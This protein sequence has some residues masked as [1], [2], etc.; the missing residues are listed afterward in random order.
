MQKSDKAMVVVDE[1]NLASSSTSGFIRVLHVD[2]DLSFLE[3]SRQILSIEG[4]F[5]IDIETSVD[6]AF[7]R[8]RSQSY[9]VVIC[10]YE[11]PK[12]DG[13]QFLKELREEKSEIPF[14]LFTGKGREEVAIKALN[15]G[16]DAY[17][18]KLGD[19]ETVYG[20]LSHALLKTVERKRSKK[21]LADSELKYRSLVEDMLQGIIIA[22]G[23]QP[24]IVFANPAMERITGFS[25]E[26]LYS[27]SP[28][29][30]G[31]LIHPSDREVFLN[32]LS[33]RYAGEDIESSYEFRGIRKDGSMT[34]VEVRSSLIEYNGHRAVQG[35]FLDITE[36]KKA[37]ELLKK[38]EEQLKAIISNAPIGIA[39]SDSNEY[40]LSANESF[41]KILG[42]SENELR[43]LTF[44]DITFE[45][46]IQESILNNQKLS[47]GQIPFFSQEKR[48]IR[49]DGAL[50]NGKITVSVMRDKEGKPVFFIAEL[51]D[52]TEKKK[53]ELELEQKYEVLDRVTE[54]IGAGLVIIGK[55][56][57]IVWANTALRKVGFVP[58][59]KCHQIFN[60]LDTVCPDCGVKKVFEQNVPYDTHEY[61]SK[62]SEGE[63]I[64]VELI[65]TPLKNR[66]GNV[67]AAIELVV[68]ITERKK[69]EE[70]LENNKNYFETLL[71][72]V[73]SGIIVVDGETREIVD[74]NPAA[75]GFI[76]ATKEEVVGKVCHQFICP[77]ENGRC[78]IMDLG[79]TL[80]KTEEVMLT[81]DGQSRPVIKSVVKVKHNGRTLLVE[82]YV[83]ISA[84][85][86]IEENLKENQARLELMNEK[87]R[88]VGGLIR[89]DVRN[90]LCGV[91]GNTYL[92]KKKMGDRTEIAG[93]VGSVEQSCKEIERL[94]DFA[95]MY[96]QLG[97]EELKYIEVDRAIN[98]ASALFSSLNLK[99]VNDCHGL[100][101]LADSFLRQMFY[102]FIDN[103]IKYG[104]KATTVRIY[105]EEIK[106][107][108]I[109]LIYEDNGVGVTTEDKPRL[110]CE[111]FSTGGSTG[112]GLFL[113]KRMMEIY[114]WEIKEAGQP[115][116]GVKFIIT[117]PMMN[118][119]GQFNYQTA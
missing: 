59:K 73:L 63:S 80:D 53:S 11:M 114:G 35:V 93:C 56:Y 42:Y 106:H 27:F 31:K 105:F 55:D 40:F 109:C 9:D 61:E 101:L 112:F 28:K 111:G 43:K 32:R 49:K 115:E 79:R 90:K 48:Y 21:Q 86:K 37:E 104:R 99:V 107:D 4:N 60:R 22:Q 45:G 19:P 23:F 87:L 91:T 15:L 118:K 14:I 108:S 57:R 102:N 81:A 51:E 100:T 54:S 94:F 52:I 85:K 76:G 95:K 25:S 88:V 62:K 84:L 65:A 24:C 6:G 29:E 68:P 7:K 110:F 70:T 72:S 64:W 58:N 46:D 82:N 20:E 38:S 74:A 78:P 116:E 83:D 41:C 44:R 16:S 89:H 67:T 97:V 18:N 13:L 34:W 47:S 36:R 30:I 33:K 39:T 98:E 3:V 17:I 1:A 71:N 66:D 92:I 113:S 12:K 8:L 119:K 10:D 5:E 103:T 69:A 2:D 50:I 77:N 75:M 96:E 26:E 117:I